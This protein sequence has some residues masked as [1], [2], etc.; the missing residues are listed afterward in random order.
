MNERELT[1]QGIEL[2]E[3]GQ[4]DQALHKF[5]EAFR[6]NPEYYYAP[7]NIGHSYLELARL[8]PTSRI[9]F[10]KLA[11][12]SLEQ[13][14]SIAPK[15]INAYI[16]LCYVEAGLDNTDEMIKAYDRAKAIEPKNE[17]VLA[18][19]SEIEELRGTQE[20]VVDEFRQLL[21]NY[22]KA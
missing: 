22:K 17:Y 4:Y 21:S 8:D 3:L 13:C 16:I 11:K 19:E 18:M 5:Q 14:I 10:L 20:S 15:Y 7:Y 2:T 9:E 6:L 1:K 12:S